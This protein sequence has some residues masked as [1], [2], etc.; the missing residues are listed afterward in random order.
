MNLYIARDFDGSLFLYTIKPELW[1][2]AWDIPHRLKLKANDCPSLELKTN[3]FPDVKFE[4]KKYKTIKFEEFIRYI[5][6]YNGQ[7]MQDPEEKAFAKLMTRL[8]L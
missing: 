7:I 3:M 6:A 5:I 2:L 8:A 4:D 1:G